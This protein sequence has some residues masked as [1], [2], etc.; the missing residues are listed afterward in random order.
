[1]LSDADHETILALIKT[2]LASTQMA[3]KR[4]PNK[5]SEDQKKFR[6]MLPGPSDEANVPEMLGFA[7]LNAY[8]ES[9]F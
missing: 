5:L 4:A 7:L 6:E 1:M 2:T 3:F 8:Y 9:A